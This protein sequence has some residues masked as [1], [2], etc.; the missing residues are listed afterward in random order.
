MA[1]VYLG[2]GTNLGDRAANLALA[3]DGLAA[4]PETRFLRMAGVYETR[5]VGGPPGQDDFYN[6]ACLVDTSL[7]PRRML[8]EIHRL[9]RSIGRRR[10]LERIAWG[11]R[12]IDIDILL[13]E[14]VEMAEPDLVIPHPRLATRAF[15][16]APLAELAPGLRHPAL[17]LGIGEL[18][19]R[20]GPQHEGIRRLSL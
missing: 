1:N 6:S 7:V 9:E 15:A 11:P 16:L 2:L 17:G 13:W 3:R 8:E 14:G 18:L 10:E 5:P 19:E 4:L 12:V 20:I